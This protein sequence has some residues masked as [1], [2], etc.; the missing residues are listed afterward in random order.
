MSEQYGHRNGE[1][2]PPTEIFKYYFYEGQIIKPGQVRGNR[3]YLFTIVIEGRMD[4]DGVLYPL[5]C[6]V[7]G[8]WWGPIVPP[9]ESDA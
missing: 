8:R 9:W 6:A 2:E 1:T 3:R 5:E 4:V 7:G